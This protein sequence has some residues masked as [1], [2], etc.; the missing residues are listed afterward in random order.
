MVKDID[1]IQ[2]A[3]DKIPEELNENAETL[4]KKEAKSLDDQYLEQNLRHKDIIFEWTQKV[5]KYYLIFVG[6]LISLIAIKVP[7]ASEYF[8][9]NLSDEVIITILA[10][11]TATI[12]GL[13]ALII[14][15]LFPKDKKKKRK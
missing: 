3:F 2:D 1:R 10:T 5:V 14:T 15:S 4:A 12:V 6:V 13:V 7:I 11:T 9:I 8:S